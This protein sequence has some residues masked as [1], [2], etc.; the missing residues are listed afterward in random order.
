MNRFL[1]CLVA[2]A[3]L[4]QTVGLAAERPAGLRLV[5]VTTQT[6]PASQSIL[7]TATEPAS[8]TTHQPDPL[9]VL[10]TL[11]DVDAG[12]IVSRLTPDSNGPVGA[13]DVAD[14]VDD[15]GAAVAEVR[16]T[17]HKPVRYEVRSRRQTIQVRFARLA[18]TDAAGDGAPRAPAA[19]AG[20]PASAI[21]SVETAIDPNVLGVTIRG[22]GALRPT[23]IYEAEHLPP[24]LVLDFPGLAVEAPA[25]TAVQL[26]PVQRVR[27][28]RNS[29]E[30]TRVVLDLVRPSVY[31]VD[32]D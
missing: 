19:P 4:T 15:E 32:R 14:A 6:T 27:V 3:M 25:M 8:Y 26:D 20:R 16:I 22:D 18:S 13:V 12:D 1:R 10:V 28:A 31:E 30:I 2:L 7:I 29:P 5:E 23:R 24:R 11:R 21:V 9:T 17:L